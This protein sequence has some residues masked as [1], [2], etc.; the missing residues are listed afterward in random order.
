MQLFIYLAMSQ[1]II[2]FFHLGILTKLIE[3]RSAF[4]LSMEAL[5]DLESSGAGTGVTAGDDD[6]SGSDED[7]FM[8]GA[9]H[10]SPERTSDQSRYVATLCRVAGNCTHVYICKIRFSTFVNFLV[11]GVVL[12]IDPVQASERV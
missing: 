6:M 8:L 1:I 3:I 11:I 9:S 10:T 2:I 12:I 5:T 7:E 4:G